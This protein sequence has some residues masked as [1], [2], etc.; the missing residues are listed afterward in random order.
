MQRFILLVLLAFLPLTVGCQVTERQE[1]GVEQKAHSGEWTDD[2]N[3]KNGGR[4][5]SRVLSAL[6]GAA[7]IGEYV[8]DDKEREERKSTA[9]AA[10]SF[11]LRAG[12]G[13]ARVGDYS[14]S[15][16]LEVEIPIALGLSADI[17]YHDVR[18]ED[19]GAHVGGNGSG[20][21]IDIAQ[22]D[23]GG[24]FTF[25]YLRI[26]GLRIF[27]YVGAGFAILGL[28]ETTYESVTSSTQSSSDHGGYLRWGVNF[29]VTG[30]TLVGFDYKR[31]MDT[32]ISDYDSVGIVIGIRF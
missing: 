27:P 17:A 16:G 15:L 24:R 21:D 11:A 2:S 23:L 25:N 6:V 5:K 26:S 10:G 3:G 22:V 30:N 20:A 14:A 19:L 31:V 28:D 7:K 4:S 9:V 8:E 29:L 18:L 12:G 1:W 32:S 13:A